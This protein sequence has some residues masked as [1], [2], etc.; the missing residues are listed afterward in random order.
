MSLLTIGTIKDAVRK[1]LKPSTVMV[2]RW[3]FGAGF[4]VLKNE[5]VHYWMDGLHWMDTWRSWNPF[6]AYFVWYSWHKWSGLHIYARKRQTTRFKFCSYLVA[7]SANRHARMTCLFDSFELD[8]KSLG[9]SYKACLSKRFPI[10]DQNH[11]QACNSGN[12]ESQ[13]NPGAPGAHEIH[14]SSMSEGCDEQRRL[15]WLLMHELC[16][17]S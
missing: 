2:A 4:L 16:E 14:A 11:S 3:W 13:Y 15:H 12:L 7:K 10:R 9:Y 17:F 8:W 1:F 6:T 5:Q